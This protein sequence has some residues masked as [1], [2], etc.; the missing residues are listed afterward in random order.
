MIGLSAT[1]ASISGIIYPI[2][3]RQLF[4][5]VGFGWAIR[6]FGFLIFVLI[7]I[8]T[9]CLKPRY[10]GRRHGRLFD[11]SPFRDTV[12]CLLVFGGALCLDERRF[13][14]QCSAFLWGSTTAYSRPRTSPYGSAQ[15]PTWRSTAL[16]SFQAHR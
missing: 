3:L 13:F 1:G 15:A 16:R 2:M 14:A 5:R 8:G 4:V 11:L 9:V 6:I 7:A 12:F 10:V